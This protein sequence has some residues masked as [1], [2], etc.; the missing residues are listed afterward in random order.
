M[1]I[2]AQPIMLLLTGNAANSAII[3]PV[4]AVMVTANTL[5]SLMVLPQMLQ[6]ACG[7][8]WIVLR[9]NLFQAIPYVLL[10]VLLAPRFGMYAPAGLWL[11]TTIVSFPVMTAMTHQLAM[12]GQAWGWFKGAILLPACATAT[13]AGRRV[14][15]ARTQLCRRFGGGPIKCLLGAIFT[16]SPAR[17]EVGSASCRGFQRTLCSLASTCGLTGESGLDY[18]QCKETAHERLSNI[19]ARI[20]QNARKNPMSPQSVVPS[21]VALRTASLETTSRK[22]G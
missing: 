3:A 11:A 10:L 8:P 13:V 5:G 21:T 2:Y 14:A 9:I 16:F 12:Q 19:A 22:T 18:V 15:M 4:F 17:L 7:A 20:P 6:L 1:L